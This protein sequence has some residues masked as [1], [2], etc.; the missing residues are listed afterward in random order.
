MRQTASKASSSLSEC[1]RESGFGMGF[2]PV[3]PLG[4]CVTGCGGGFASCNTCAGLCRMF[5]PAG[6]HGSKAL[7]HQS[8]EVCQTLMFSTNTY[9][10]E[11]DPA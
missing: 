9:M 5:Y 4:T 7:D 11:E 8:L 10:K 1:T 3:M 2:A 6:L